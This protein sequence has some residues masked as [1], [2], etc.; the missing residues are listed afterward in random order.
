M[1]R[2]LRRIWDLSPHATDLLVE[3]IR[4]H[5]KY[6]AISFLASFLSALM[7]GTTLALLALA[8][9]SLSNAEVS[10]AGQAAA[11]VSESIGL[12]R[13]GVFIALVAA[14]VVSQV[15]HSG[16][17][18]V[19]DVANGSLQAKVE[20]SVRI[21]IFDR[22][23]DFSYGEVRK[24]KVG[25]L[26]SH[27]DQVNFLGMALNRM[28]EVVAQVLMLGVYTLLLF[29]LS[30]QATLISTAAMVLLSLV[31]RVLVR[32]VRSA[33]HGYKNSVVRVTEQA[34]E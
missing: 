8:L 18:F 33:A 20:Q 34:I 10:R 26:S 4:R 24:H 5:R 6:V 28:H 1:K 21:R 31:M 22:F 27:M 16:L 15:L 19:S 7:E 17:A 32:R 23:L 14:A 2:L 30:W 9:E 12:G 3:L 13:D 25:Q 11:S 29:W